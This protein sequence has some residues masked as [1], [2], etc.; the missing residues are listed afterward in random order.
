ME[1][2]TAKSRQMH[3]PYKTGAEISIGGSETSH[4]VSPTHTALPSHPRLDTHFVFRRS[5]TTLAMSLLRTAAVLPRASSLISRTTA[6]VVAAR[7]G[8]AFRQHARGVHYENSVYHVRRRS[9]CFI[10]SS[11]IFIVIYRIHHS[12]MKT[13]RPS[14]Q[15][16]SA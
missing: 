13:R 5:T 6:S 15:A 1:S 4:S 11:L 12:I 10:R 3:K 14:P 16:T 2:E 9:F 7:A 8:H